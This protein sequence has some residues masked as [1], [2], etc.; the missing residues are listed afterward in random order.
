M[1]QL[2]DILNTGFTDKGAHYKF[3]KHD[4]KIFFGDLN[5]RINLPFH[6]VLETI[7]EMNESN[8]KENMGTLK[9]NDQLNQ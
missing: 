7:E 4:V 8:K 2:R 9:S 1:Q 5:F 3:Y 6:S